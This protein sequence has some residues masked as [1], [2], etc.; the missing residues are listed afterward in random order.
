MV[1]NILAKRMASTF[2]VEIEG[3]L[4]SETSVAPTG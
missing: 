3:I 2:S 4:S 1:T